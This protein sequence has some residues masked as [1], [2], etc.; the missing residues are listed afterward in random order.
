[1]VSVK[2]GIENLRDRIEPLANHLQRYLLIAEK[3]VGVLLGRLEEEGLRQRVWFWDVAQDLGQEM[4]VVMRVGRTREEKLSFLGTYLALQVVHLN[5]S[6]LDHHALEMARS[7]LPWRPMK[8]FL[9]RSADAFQE[10]L[11]CYMSRA[12]GLLL[13]PGEAPGYLVL[14]VGGRWDRDDQDICV[15]DDG[16]PRR[17]NLRRAVVRLS[18]EMLRY[19]ARVDFHLAEEVGGNQYSA[20]VEEYRLFL[21]RSPRDFISASEILGAEIM[22]GSTELFSR[23]RRQVKN[24]FFYRGGGPSIYHEAYLRG[25]LGEVM[26]LAT[27]PVDETTL[28]P[29]EDVLRP[30]KGI[31]TVYQALH[32]MEASDP[33]RLLDALRRRAPEKVPLL[34]RLEEHL[35]FFETFRQLYHFH[36]E[37]TE[38]IHLGE[39]IPLESRLLIAQLMG[40]E[41][42]G[43]VDAWDGLLFRY[44]QKVRL[45]REL[46]LHFVDLF[47]VHLRRISVFTPLLDRLEER[48]E[49]EVDNLALLFRLGRSFRGTGYWDDLLDELRESPP[50][51][52]RLVDEILALD[53]RRRERVLRRLSA[54]VHA[55][56]RGI[57]ELITLCYPYK[58]RE[59][60]DQVI[61]VLVEGFLETLG[62]EPDLASRLVN[63]FFLRPKL[64]C[65]LLD[66][67]SEEEQHRVA[68]IL[69]AVE[70]EE[71]GTLSQAQQVRR[72]CRLFYSHSRYFQRFFLRVVDRH[73]AI[74]PHLTNVES[75]ERIASGLKAWDPVRTGTRTR[76]E[77]LGDAFDME[78]VQLGFQALTSPRT[79]EM[80]ESFNRFF[81]P[82]IASLFRVCRQELIERDGAEHMVD[83]DMGLFITGSTARGSV[84]AED[85]DLFGLCRDEE[86]IPFFSRALTM[87][88]QELTRRGL[89]AHYCLVDA[90]ETPVCTAEMLAHHLG[91]QREPA[92]VEASILLGAKLAVGGE[93]F[94]R[95]LYRDLVEPHIYD[96]ALKYIQGMATEVE[97]I[98]QDRGEEYNL[99]MKEGLG[100][101]RCQE[102]TILMLKAWGRITL[103]SSPGLVR[104]MSER[105]PE[106]AEYLLDLADTMVF[107]HSLRDIYWVTVSGS[108]ILHP[109]SLDRPARVM[110]I[111]GRNS[112]ERAANLLQ[113]FYCERDR[114]GRACLAIS[115]WVLRQAGG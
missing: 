73:P 46:V 81:T 92:V 77:A 41:S 31:I 17:T 29:K 62:S 63:V 61:S 84:F 26:I 96:Q 94:R 3:R 112:Q 67:L 22:F 69:R 24:L 60:M 78:V 111:R 27:K 50:I 39:D 52:D 32:G 108:N 42:A 9:R 20:S 98:Q 64:V 83:A 1:M 86:D 90:V 15:V 103:P 106:I 68:E 59:G 85:C 76:K 82:Y 40:Y 51:L 102:M 70:E 10:M 25:N 53:E 74:V 28:R 91:R 36:V 43:T 89:L 58:R 33:L 6:L 114:S 18:T 105:W 54:G 21:R 113:R 12:M 44:H 109:E 101:F 72:F 80:H 66:G 13:P 45:A 23:F 37:E 16:T 87:A 88:G 49:P 95:I 99:D 56:T 55:T 48:P 104:R 110:N 11:R 2:E 14:N 93:V 115:R 57:M 47:K 100:G 38:V 65:D 79:G 34:E 7:T 97:T 5:L 71:E 107:L 75:L 19:A 8:I 30:I 35:V 4:D